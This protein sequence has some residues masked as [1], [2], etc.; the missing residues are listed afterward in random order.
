MKE[1][2]GLLAAIL[3]LTT[4]VI[5]LLAALNKTDTVEVP[6]IREIQVLQPSDGNDGA[7]TTE[8]TTTTD[9]TESTPTTEV[10]P[11]VGLPRQDAEGKIADARLVVANVDTVACE[12]VEQSGMVVET[13]PDVGTALMEGD[14]VSL[15]VCE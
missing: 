8:P 1:G 9:T 7:T 4:A 13:S 3:G 11:I 15:T 2:I 14:G 12:A 5:V 6:V 10:P